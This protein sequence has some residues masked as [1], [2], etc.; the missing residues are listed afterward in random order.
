[1]PVIDFL[2]VSA[3]AITI[4]MSDDHFRLDIWHGT[5]R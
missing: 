1:M 3:R 4:A 2:D 5:N